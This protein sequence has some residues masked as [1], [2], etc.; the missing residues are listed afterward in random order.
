ML[1]FKR[2]L[3]KITKNTIFIAVVITLIRFYVWL[4]FITCRIILIEDSKSKK[5]LIN[6]SQCFLAMW[7]ARLLPFPKVMR[8]FGYY[9]AIVSLHKDGHYIDAFI[10]SYG[11]K[12]IRGSSKKGGYSVTRKIL[13]H[14]E[15][16]QSIV[17]TPDGP[18]GPRYRANTIISNLAYKKDIP[19]IPLSY[20]ATKVKI[21]KTWDRFMLPSLFTKI[22]IEIGAP[23]VIKNKGSNEL[24]NILRSNMMQLD[25]K[26]NVTLDY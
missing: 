5:L 1:L 19:I 21:F 9:T 14:L 23:I 7:H 4:L 3:K 17:V 16:K 25:H 11:H 20:S 18:R 10:S 2:I 15:K 22:I 13:D 26:C 24:E 6:N 12:S 8:K